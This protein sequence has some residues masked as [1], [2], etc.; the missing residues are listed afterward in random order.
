MSDQALTVEEWVGDDP[1]RQRIMV[2]CEHIQGEMHAAAGVILGLT[3]TNPTRW[4]LGWSS[5]RDRYSQIRTLMVALHQEYIAVFTELEEL[6]AAGAVVDGDSMHRGVLDVL[7]ALAEKRDN[8]DRVI[9]S[10]T[11]W[12]KDMDEVCKLA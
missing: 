5:L 7:G 10:Y 9:A 2:L 11:R 6:L 8:Y 4:V 1:R 3:D 12:I